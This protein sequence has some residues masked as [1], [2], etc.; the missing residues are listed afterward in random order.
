MPTPRVFID[1]PLNQLDMALIGC[2]SLSICLGIVWRRSDQLD[3][4]VNSE[5]PEFLR[6]ED[7]S[8]IGRDGLRNPKPVNNMLFDK[9]D[10]IL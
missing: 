9:I 10:N 5:L 3:P 6:Y 1:F 2:L 7:R 4:H 8:S